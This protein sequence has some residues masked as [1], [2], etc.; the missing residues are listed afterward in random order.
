MRAGLKFDYA[1]LK[2][3]IKEKELTQE[4]FSSLIGIGKTSLYSKFKNQTE[5]KQSEIMKAV[6]VLGIPKREI[7]AYFFT[8]KV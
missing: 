4:E 7:N 5:F 2:G 3:R 8:P 1:K 6:K